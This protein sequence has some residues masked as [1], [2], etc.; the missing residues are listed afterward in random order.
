MS[1]IAFFF[2]TICLWA[3]VT[4]LYIACLRCGRYL[5]KRKEVRG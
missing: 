5:H 2:A 3:A 1:S 4:L